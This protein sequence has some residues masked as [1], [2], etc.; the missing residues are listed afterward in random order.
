MMQ[1]GVKSLH[2]MMQ[3]RVKLMYFAD[4]FPLH[5]AVVSQILPPHDA[6]G[7]QFGSGQPKWQRGVKSKNFRRL[8]R[9][10]KGQACKKSHMG[11]L[12]YHVPMR[13]IYYNSPSLQLFS[14]SPRQNK[15]TFGYGSGVQVGTS[16]GKNRR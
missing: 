6:A 14:D 2:C 11:D 12:Y 8:P 7:S 4:I 16:D 15:D 13:I 3:R 9:P 10:L 1:R 5:H